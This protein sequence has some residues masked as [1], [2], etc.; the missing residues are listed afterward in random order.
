MAKSVKP[1]PD[2]SESDKQRFFSKVSPSPNGKGCLEWLAGKISDGYGH[3]WAGGKTYRA[4]RIAYFLAT[5]EDP[6]LLQAR[7]SCHV[8]HCVN[9]A[10]LRPGTQQDNSDD[11]VVAGRAARGDRNGT[12]LYPERLARGDRNGAR[13]YPERLARGEANHNSKLKESDIS[14]IRADTRAQVVIALEYGVSQTTI[15]AI[16][17]FAI[18]VTP[19]K[20]PQHP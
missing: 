15:S 9:P 11:M 12:H 14:L 17:R 6:H 1:L 4:H 10:H 19:P 7:H 5:G 13:L 16:K 3:F 2:L 8:R 18:W 20:E